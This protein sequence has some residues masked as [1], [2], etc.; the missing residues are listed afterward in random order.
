MD[1]II[2]RSVHLIILSTIYIALIDNLAFW[3]QL[4]QRLY[5]FELKGFGLGLT[6]FLL[7][8]GV[9]ALFFLV[10]GQRFLLKPLLILFLIGS[11]LIAYFNSI[12][13]V[14]DKDMIHSMLETV[15]DH[16][17][18][19]ATELLSVSLLTQLFFFGLLPSVFVSMMKIQYKKLLPELLMRIGYAL[20][21][22]TL[23]GVL[24]ML[25]FKYVT[26]F[27]R[28]NRD[29]RMIIAPIFPIASAVKLFN[30]SN[31]NDE[32]PFRIIGSDAT[33]SHGGRKRVGILLVGETARAD[34]FSLNGYHRETNPL[35]SKQNVISY[36]NVWSCGTSTAYS[37]P[38][39]FSLLEREGYSPGEAAKQSNVLDI[40]EKAGVKT[41]WHD[42]NSSCKGVCERIETENFHHDYDVASPFYNQGEYVDEIL[43]DKL[44]T[45]IKATQSDVLIVLHTMGSHGPA[46]YKRYPG[47]FAK[48]KPICESNSP[49]ECRDD[50]VANA[51]DNT[52]VYTDFILNKSIALLKKYAHTY[53]TFMLYVSDH[54][55]SLGENGIYL[56]GLPYVIAPDAQKH[57]PLV[58]WLSEGLKQAKGL[59][60]DMIAAFRD[61]PVS[62]DYLAH[63][64]LGLFNIET[65]LYKKKLNLFSGLGIMEEE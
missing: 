26:Y 54:G 3:L 16:N 6:L 11:S 57:V 62:H 34:H 49:Y 1:G 64:L 55:E 25:N 18:N 12:G 41:Y 40:L 60:D 22:V 33:Q 27:S 20:G 19:E 23:I 61:I 10:I 14:F 31:A 30:N 9:L 48:F 29:L 38:C 37:V 7:I 45:L 51:Y 59:D 65:G 47:A 53:D 46:Y 58:A 24:I 42:N 32:I 21:I 15:K 35:L 5:L 56:H 52:I 36:R 39:M 50:L 4:S 8:S 13:V 28:E 63:T 43:L 44:G 17:N 2:L